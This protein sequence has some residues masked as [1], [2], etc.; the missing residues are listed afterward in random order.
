ML[1][2][3]KEQIDVL[4]L[5][6]RQLVPFIRRIAKRLTPVFLNFGSTQ[7]RF[8]SFADSIQTIKKNRCL[9]LS[10]IAA[11]AIPAHIDSK[12]QIR[13]V[14]AETNWVLSASRIEA[15]DDMTIAVALEN[16]RLVFL[17]TSMENA[18]QRAN[19]PLIIVLPTG[20]DEDKPHVFLISEI[21]SE[22][23]VIEA[24]APLE[25]GTSFPIVEIVGDKRILR[26]AAATVTRVEPWFMP[27]GSQ[28]FRCSLDLSQPKV[29]DASSVFDT[30]KDVLRVKKIMASIGMLT[31]YGWYE[32]ASNERGVVR[33]L[34][35]ER[36]SALLQF[37]SPRIPRLQE[38][39]TIRIGVEVFAV[40]YE[41]EVRILEVK[42]QQIRVT[43]PLMLRKRRQHRRAER[44]SVPEQTELC[45]RFYNPT[46]GYVRERSV[47]AISYV[48]LTF[49]RYN[50]D[51]VWRSLILERAE[52][53]WKGQRIRLGDLTVRSTSERD[54]KQLCHTSINNPQMANNPVLVNLIATLSHP[55][56]RFYDGDD[57][58]SLIDIYFQAGLISP[59]MHRNLEPIIEE[60]KTVWSKLHRGAPDIVRTLIQGPADSPKIAMTSIRG[61]E[62][63]WMAQHFVNVDPKFNRAIGRLQLAQLDHVLPRS[64]GHYILFFVK[65]DNKV[66]N[67]FMRNFFFSTGSED[68][69]T[70]ITI[71]LWSRPGDR[72]VES[73][74]H[75]QRF[76]MRPMRRKEEELV[77]RA[78][79]RYLGI[80]P[81][82]ALSM[83]PGEFSLPTSSRC[84]SRAGLLRD[85]ICCVATYRK[86]PVYAVLEERSSPGLNLTW[87]L[88]AN[89]IL[90]I[91]PRVDHDE[92][93]LSSVLQAIINAPT[94]S[95]LG[96]RFLNVPQNTPKEPFLKAGFE[97]L[98]PVNL[99][100]LNRAGL[101]RYY[102]YA[103]SRYGEMNA[104]VQRR[105]AR[106]QNATLD[107]K[108][109]AREQ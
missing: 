80:L 99:Y 106:K 29:T 87:M 83:V 27:D 85:R 72:R 25:L 107:S 50:Q 40:Y 70:T 38:R 41:M 19:D 33:F 28:R 17:P 96:D 7:P 68:S 12:I 75:N 31:A 4:E 62:R 93:V 37:D 15:L 86:Q 3:I 57:F 13:P 35:V 11:Q 61:W 95:R 76:L 44:V 5:N 59:H 81:A 89:W 63:A 66:M 39:T 45:V 36:D 18:L 84:F 104:L 47:A 60:A 52:L 97:L 46:T 8:R 82:A 49:H 1:R 56:I 71:E 105:N 9:L 101:Q 78:A 23:C 98:A 20:I 34:R 51:P 42:G 10:P 67:A 26:R 24:T 94:C 77:A 91:H 65:A 58:S 16:A 90:P 54:G 30:T 43:L 88:N 21:S 69:V 48:G 108:P 109:N 73:D 100:V 22:A 32:A 64:D 14:T 53:I 79:Q 103:A 102:Y 74:V 55:D 6:G 92:K 2:S